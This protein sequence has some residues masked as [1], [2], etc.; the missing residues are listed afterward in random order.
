V[1]NAINQLQASQALPP[2]FFTS[3]HG[4]QVGWLY[5]HGDPRFAAI[6]RLCVGFKEGP[7]RAASFLQ[8]IVPFPWMRILFSSRWLLAEPRPTRQPAS[9]GPALQFKGRE[10]VADY[11]ISHS[12]QPSLKPNTIPC[13]IRARTRHGIL[14]HWLPMTDSHVVSVLKVKRMGS[15][16]ED[17]GCALAR[18]RQQ[19][20]CLARKFVGISRRVRANGKISSKNSG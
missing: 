11:P 14:C 16:R 1:T 4:L 19:T 3:S 2:S 17:L 9:L 12:G 5:L 20:V 7:P 18:G 8:S 10:W 15:N 6:G 13:S